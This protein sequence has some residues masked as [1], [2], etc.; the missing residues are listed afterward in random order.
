MNW[1]LIV[2]L[3]FWAIISFVGFHKGF[4]RMLFS[5]CAL[6]LSLILTLAFYPKVDEF[7]CSSTGLDEFLYEKYSLYIDKN[8][9]DTSDEN[10]SVIQSLVKEMSIDME[11]LELES[12]TDLI[13]SGATAA[14]NAVNEV[15]KELKDALSLKLAHMTITVLAFL[16]TWIVISIVLRIILGVIK[17]I[18]KIPVIRGMNR[19]L[20]F[21]LG[22]LT[23]LLVIW[24]AFAIITAL[25][26]SSFGNNCIECIAESGLLTALYKTNIFIKLL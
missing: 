26:A 8:E 5:V 22:A 23:G 18:E 25:A 6:I 13:D 16:I 15:T 1:L 21:V 14:G 19:A 2:V 7:L 3:I 11:N 20:G 24:A 10:E 9:A 4:L 12:I 17:I